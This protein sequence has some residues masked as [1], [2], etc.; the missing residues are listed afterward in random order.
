M[1]IYIKGMAN[2]RKTVKKRIEGFKEE[3]T[4][5]IIKLCIYPNSR[6]KQHWIDELATWFTDIAN[7]T[8]KPRSAK[9]NDYEYDFWVFGEFGDAYE[10]VTSLVHLWQ[11]KNRRT[12]KYPN[13]EV[14]DAAMDHLFTIVSR[15]RAEL[16][17]LFTGKD[18]IE[19]IQMLKILNRLFR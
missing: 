13:I 11:I 4:S 1:K 17:P 16:I 6:D 9:F 18:K 7:L 10:D 2:D 5:N 3:I 19:R 12:G 8:L 15:L 14:A